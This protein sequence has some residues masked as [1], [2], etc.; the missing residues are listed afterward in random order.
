[1]S[2]SVNKAT[3]LGL[4]G[5]DLE[6]RETKQGKKIAHFSLATHDR[7]RDQASGEMHERTE[8]HRIVIFNE[9]LANIAEAYLSKGKRV[10]LEGQIQ[11]RHWD[12]ADGQ[13]R[14]ITEIVLSSY[15]SQLTLLDRQDPAADEE[16]AS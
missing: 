13:P 10:Y 15:Q 4:L 14:I 3:L 8:W 1:M 11:T 9:N 12:N 5:Q 7:W 6:I 16:A 2:H